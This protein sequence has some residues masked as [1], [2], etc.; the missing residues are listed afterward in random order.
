MGDDMALTQFKK[1]IRCFEKELQKINPSDK[2][3]P[4]YIIN[5]YSG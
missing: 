2:K 3:A 1:V 4:L 5:R